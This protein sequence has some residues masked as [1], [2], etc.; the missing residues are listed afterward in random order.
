V[1]VVIFETGRALAF[2]MFEGGRAINNGAL[3]PEL[4]IPNAGPKPTPADHT[5]F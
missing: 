3:H 4:L 5:G 1:W 2:A